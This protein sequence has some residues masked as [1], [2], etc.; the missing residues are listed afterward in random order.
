[1]NSKGSTSI[2]FVSADTGMVMTQ[3]LFVKAQLFEMTKSR[4]QVNMILNMTILSQINRK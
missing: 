2:L 4:T 3:D 1:M